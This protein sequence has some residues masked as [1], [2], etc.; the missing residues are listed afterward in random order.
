M[1]TQP[2]ITLEIF[3]KLAA[4]FAADDH[5]F[6]P[7]RNYVYIKETPLCE[8]IEEVDLSWEWRIETVNRYDPKGMIA[9]TIGHLTIC[10]I[11]RSGEG[12][13]TVEFQKGSDLESGEAEKGSET[14]ALKRAARKFGVGRYLLQCPKDVKEYGPALN[15]WLTEVAKQ[16]GAPQAALPSFQPTSIP[17]APVDM[18]R[19][20]D[21]VRFPKFL[22]WAKATHNL[23]ETDVLRALYKINGA[24]FKQSPAA[25]AKAAVEA[26]A[27]SVVPLMPSENALRG[28]DAS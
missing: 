23:T 15:K 1:T 16:Q 12:S 25:Q 9:T 10:G 17:A 4:P 7:P 13:Q 3:K 24:T 6:K 20:D 26:W 27:A 8:R 11:T 14:D 28:K 21:A 5:E 19:L 22:A 18:L 2:G